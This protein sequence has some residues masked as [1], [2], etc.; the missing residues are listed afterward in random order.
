MTEF[1]EP[2]VGFRLWY[3]AEPVDY[4]SN[5]LAD[6]WGGQ[7]VPARHRLHNGW[8]RSVGSGCCGWGTGTVEAR[9]HGLP[10]EAPA[11]DCSCGLYAYDRL[12]TAKLY[13]DGFDARSKGALVMGAVLLWGRVAYAQVVD[14]YERKLRGVD[15]GLRL[16]AQY[17]RIL[18]LRDDREL[19]DQACRLR[20]IPAVSERYLEA[21]AREH[22]RQV[23][24]GATSRSV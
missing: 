20:Q 21:V 19:T 10:H 16:R 6:S 17:G 4:W 5:L 24:L 22:G 2:V 13:E 18:A 7:M 12:E 15:L 14:R 3:A 23:R 9:C 11:L 1:D 8:L